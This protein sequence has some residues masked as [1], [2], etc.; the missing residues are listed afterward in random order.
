MLMSNEFVRAED[1]YRRQVLQDQ[2]QTETKGRAGKTVTAL[3]V[4]GA[5][6]LAACGVPAEGDVGAANTQSAI[7]V[8]NGPTWEPNQAMLEEIL[9]PQESDAEVLAARIETK[10]FGPMPAPSW[11]PSQAALDAVFR[12]PDTGSVNNTEPFGHPNYGRLEN[13]LGAQPSTGIR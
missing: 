11:Q 13:Y 10:E 8:D 2:Y 6:A 7:L 12:Q 3:V 4:A 1:N 5:I 9:N